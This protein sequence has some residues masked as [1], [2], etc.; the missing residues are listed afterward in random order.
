MST[1]DA[2]AAV[3]ATTASF[4]Q[5]TLYGRVDV[6]MNNQKTTVGNTWTKANNLVNEDGLSTGLIGI[7]GSEDLGGGMSAS[8]VQEWDLDLDTG[9][10]NFDVGRNSTLGLAGGFGAVRLGRSYTPLFSTIGAS[11]VFGTTGATTVNAYPDG[12]RASNALFYTSPNFGG[13]TVDFMATNNNISKNAAV[14]KN[15]SI[16]L[17][18]TYA[19]GPLMARLGYGKMSTTTGAV[20]GETKGTAIA[21]TYDLGS[22]KVYFGYTTGTKEADVSVNTK[23]T[24]KETNLGVAVPMGAITLKAGYGKNKVEDTVLGAVTKTDGNDFV[25]GADYALSK[26]TTAYFKTGTYNK[27]DTTKTTRTS[28]GLRHTF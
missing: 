2:L 13:V 14:D 4:A 11:D 18:A 16:G 21:A 26:R 24:T 8:F 12:V 5:V 17:S 23:T 6:G 1:V 19:A 27:V 9:R 25:V 28:I 20:K 3:A 10:M 22:A 15:N 7:K